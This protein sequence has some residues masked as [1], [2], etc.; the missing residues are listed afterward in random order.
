MMWDCTSL[1][2]LGASLI[3]ALGLVLR[4]AKARS[5]S[6]NQRPPG[7]PG[8]PIIG[9]ILD[10]GDAPHQNLHKLRF[11]YGPVLWL[12]LGSVNTMVIQSA[13]A[14]E[15]L[16]RNHDISVCG[17][18]VPDSLTALSYHQGSVVFGN[19]GEYWRRIRRLCTAEFL[20]NKRLKE[21]ATL[22]QK[23][24][25]NMIHWIEEDAEM[26]RSQGG[27]REVEIS[28]FLF[29]MA[30]NVLSNLMLSRDLLEPQSMEGREFFDA[31]NKIMDWAGK[32]NLA[33]YLSFLK[34][35]DPQ[36]IKKNME[37]DMGR[38]MKIISEFVNERVK[39]KQS[40]TEK[41][42]RDFLDVLLEHDEG[43]NEGSDKISETNVNII[44][45]EM[46]LAGS[47]TTSGVIEWAMAE[48]LRHPDSMREVKEELDR[49][50]GPNRKVE[51][52]DMDQLP[53]LQAVVKETFRLHS[54][55]PLLVPRKT[56]EDLNYMG[57]FIPK[58]TQVIV[59][60]WA[61][62]RDPDHWEDPSSFR[63]ERFLGKNTEYKGQHFDLIP[64]GSGR[65][66]CVGLPLAHRTVPLALAALLH[67]FEWE[68]DSSVTPETMDM[69][70]RIGI[71]LRKLTPL[72]AKPTRR[73]GMENDG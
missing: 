67:S 37:R 44:I 62:G 55:A 73:G 69:S 29:L 1:A 20:V 16:F 47:E 27:S 34:W 38:A 14:A 12:Q 57:Y 61:I 36:G 45:V 56:L 7:P 71:T 3:A 23:C 33:D 43:G 49:V 64:F 22:R 32:P 26:S 18:M 41:A 13:K 58:S 50:L 65:R 19:Y 42:T 63:P 70:E 15:E 51:E 30:F 35:L 17:R 72:K 10:L 31:M 59:N 39:Q 25:D 66:M 8:W 21:T 9:N 60:A 28:H 48:L 5:G 52:N 68:L 46:Y 24:I 6:N 11:K 40:G 4:W 53:Y 2:W 54:P